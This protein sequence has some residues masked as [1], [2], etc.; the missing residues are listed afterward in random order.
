[1]SRL[2][3]ATCDAASATLLTNAINNYE[4]SN[5]YVDQGL[6]VERQ[7]NQECMQ[8]VEGLT[9]IEPETTAP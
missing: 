9:I 5:L 6:L 4:G 8:M 1:M 2:G 7:R 3:F